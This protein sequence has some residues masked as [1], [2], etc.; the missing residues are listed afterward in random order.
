M[1]CR[2]ST[3]VIIL[4]QEHLNTNLSAQISIQ[5][6]ILPYVTLGLIFESVHTAFWS[7]EYQ[8]FNPR[9]DQGY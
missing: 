8:A 6:L 4:L 2:T 7:L 9:L 5:I 3:H 1:Q